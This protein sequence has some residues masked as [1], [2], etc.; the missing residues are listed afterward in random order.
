MSLRLAARIAAMGVLLQALFYWVANVIPSWEASDFLQRLRLADLAVFHPV[1]WIAYFLTIGTTRN[2]TAAKAA[3]ALLA[4]ELAFAV[5]QQYS[6]LSLISLET[7][8]FVFG[9]VLPGLCWGL[10]LLNRR[11]G[12]P[13]L[14]LTSL[15][16]TAYA[17][18]QVASNTA[19]IR[20]FW[21]DDPWRLLAAPA[22][23]IVFW[24]SQTLFIRAAQRNQ[25]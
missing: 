5:Y 15:L 4:I 7:M 17:V 14:L 19:V 3:C 18:Y 20:A 24:A 23:W 10:Y 13:Y 25:T 8:A 2:R 9:T 22:I 1:A 12:L 11:A 21:Q 16:Q 6:T